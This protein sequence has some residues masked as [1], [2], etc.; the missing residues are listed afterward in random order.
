[1][2]NLRSNLM[3]AFMEGK[4]K[5]KKGTFWNFLTV[6][7]AI[8]IPT[9]PMSWSFMLIMLSISLM[10]FCFGKTVRNENS[11]CESS[12]DSITSF[13][14]DR[15][16]IQ[17]GFCSEANHSTR[18]NLPDNLQGKVWFEGRATLSVCP[19]FPVKASGCFRALTSGWCKLL[20]W[21]LGHFKS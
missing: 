16:L 1:M 18:V 4:K 6:R 2:S 20:L 14:T 11:L 5:K 12:L 3:Q 10:Q 17:V 9:I 13:S 21:D 7:P 15:E 8:P 19:D